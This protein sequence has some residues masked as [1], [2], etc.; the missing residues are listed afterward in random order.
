MPL[1]RSG[2]RVIKGL[3][4]NYGEEKGKSIFYAMINTGKPGSQKWHKVRTSKKGRK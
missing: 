3:K 1:T 2:K 4:K